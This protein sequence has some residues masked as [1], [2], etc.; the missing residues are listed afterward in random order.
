MITLGEKEGGSDL[1]GD[2]RELDEREGGLQWSMYCS[3][4]WFHYLWTFL[5]VCSIS[6]KK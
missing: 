3:Q 1:G 2:R 5:Y 6:V 4:W